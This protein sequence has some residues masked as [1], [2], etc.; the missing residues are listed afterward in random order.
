MSHVGRLPGIFRRLTRSQQPVSEDPFLIEIRPV[1]EV[2]AT[3]S[4]GRMRVGVDLVTICHRP[5]DGDAPVRWRFR[6][7]PPGEDIKIVSI[8]NGRI[9]FPTETAVRFIVY[10]EDHLRAELVVPLAGDLCRIN[11]VGYDFRNFVALIDHVA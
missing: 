6:I 9:V 2:L 8:P 10:L 11:R 4:R 5:A 1:V 7:E 3:P